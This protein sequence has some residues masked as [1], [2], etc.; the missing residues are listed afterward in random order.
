[1]KCI[2]HTVLNKFIR[3]LAIKQENTNILEMCQKLVKK[4]KNII[5]FIIHIFISKSEKKSEVNQTLD[6]TTKTIYLF[7]VQEFN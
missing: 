1:M 4:S 5:L 3:S 7:F 6:S 2:T